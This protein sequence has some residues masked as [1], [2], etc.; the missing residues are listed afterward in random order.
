MRCLISTYRFAVSGKVS[1]HRCKRKVRYVFD[2]LRT[3]KPVCRQCCECLVK[4]TKN[5]GVSTASERLGDRA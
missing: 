1:K 3:L 2:T 5:E 4:G